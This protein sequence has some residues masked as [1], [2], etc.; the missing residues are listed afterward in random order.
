[1]N[2]LSTAQVTWQTSASSFWLYTQHIEIENMN[3]D[4]SGITT[5]GGGHFGV[6]GMVGEMSD[7]YSS[8]GDPLFFMHHGKLDYEWNKWQRLGKSSACLLTTKT[9]VLTLF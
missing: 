4:L 7:M 2:K 8:P 6:G 5:H 1:M 9:I 3:T